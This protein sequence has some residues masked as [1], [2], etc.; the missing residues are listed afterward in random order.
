MAVAVQAQLT[1]GVVV[2]VVGANLHADAARIKP[3]AA[4]RVA[5]VGHEVVHVA[6]CDADGSG[7][8]L[9]IERRVYAGVIRRRAPTC[10][11]ATCNV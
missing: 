3:A 2:T 11:V 10:S 7:V 5:H 4:D 9:G 8:R 6:V 1:A